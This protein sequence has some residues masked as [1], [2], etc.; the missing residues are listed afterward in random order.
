MHLRADTTRTAR[1]AITIGTGN[2]VPQIRVT[3]CYIQ[4]Q[5]GAAQVLNGEVPAPQH[6]RV[7]IRRSTSALSFGTIVIQV[8]S[9]PLLGHIQVKADSERRVDPLLR[10]GTIAFLDVFFRPLDVVVAHPYLD[11]ADVRSGRQRPGRK[12]RPACP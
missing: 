4:A 3:T 2:T 12:R 5:C 6:R 11:R 10:V 9:P 1:Q 7:L 8:T